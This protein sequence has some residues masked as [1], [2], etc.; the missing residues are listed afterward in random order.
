LSEVRECELRASCTLLGVDDVR[1]LALPD[2]G[3]QWAAQQQGTL[4]VLVDLIVE[5][6]P[7][8]IVTFGPDGLYGHS[9]HVAI[10]E[11]VTE[12][13]QAVA[14]LGTADELAQAARLPAPRLFFPVITAQAIAQ[15]VDDMARAGLPS[16]LWSLTPGDFHAKQAEI[17]ASID[18]SSVLDRKLQALH[19]HR[20][21]LEHDHLFAHLTPAL[22]ARFF[23]TEHFRCAD[24]RP[25]D[26]LDG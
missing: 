20:S 2:S 19:S 10:G 22:A 6:R 16:R 12:A 26:P 11:L 13:R 18:V 25:G 24:G 8:A 17:T 1:M 21:Q 4:G 5:L 3:V 15:L 14:E 9:D 7:H 23:G